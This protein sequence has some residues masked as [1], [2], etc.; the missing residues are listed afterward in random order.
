MII[1]KQ[2]SDS[3]RLLLLLFLLLFLLLLLLLNTS[4]INIIWAFF[5]FSNR[6]PLIIPSIPPPPKTQTTFSQTKKRVI[7][8]KEMFYF[9]EGAFEWEWG[10][11]DLS[12]TSLTTGICLLKFFLF[13]NFRIKIL[14][15]V[16]SQVFLKKRKSISKLAFLCFRQCQ[17]FPQRGAGQGKETELSS[18]SSRSFFSSSSFSL[19]SVSV[20]RSKRH[21]EEERGRGKEGA[22]IQKPNMQRKVFR[23]R[24][25][26]Y[27]FGRPRGGGRKNDLG[28]GE[29]SIFWKRNLLFLSRIMTWRGQQ[30]EE[31]CEDR[32]MRA[33][34][35]AV[36]GGGFAQGQISPL[37][38][39]WKM[40]IA[41]KKSCRTWFRTKTC[42]L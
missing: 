9:R 37:S 32:F 39:N 20:P 3:N 24:W 25:I 6:P 22:S 23:F 2:G 11:S 16:L 5:F 26:I 29:R 40:P 13:L 38:E 33:E 27:F 1:L 12:K 7:D 4:C 42:D 34:G 8:Q 18:S 41:K 21:P 31:E 36:N 28:D 14:T 35:R 10:Y 17:A 30:K 15:R 19:P